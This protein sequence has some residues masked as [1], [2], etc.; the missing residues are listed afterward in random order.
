MSQE[1]ES[2]QGDETLEPPDPKLVDFPVD[3]KCPVLLFKV[4]RLI[5]FIRTY[6]LTELILYQS[7]NY[8]P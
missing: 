6:I 4:S 1:Q 7:W 3:L 5:S 2:I 8:K